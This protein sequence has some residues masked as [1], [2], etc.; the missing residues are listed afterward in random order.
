MTRQKKEAL[1]A[2]TP[3]ASISQRFAVPANQVDTI[4]VYPLGV[5]TIGFAPL[6]GLPDGAGGDRGSIKG[7]S[8]D[9]RR[10]FREWLVTHESRSSC[11]GLT[12][13]IPGDIVTPEVWH[14][15]LHALSV[16]CARSKVGLVWRLELQQR[17]QAHLHCI[18]T[19]IWKAGRVCVRNARAHAPSGDADIPESASTLLWWKIT[20]GK[21]LDRYA[22]KCDGR[23]FDGE[24]VRDVKDCPR[25]LLLGADR[26]M[27]DLS[28]DTG[29]PVW[30]RYLCDH[31]TKSKQAQ[32]CGWDGVRHWGKMHSSAFRQ[33]SPEVWTVE[34]PLYLIAYRWIRNSTRR[35]IKDERAPFG[36]R[37][38]V[39][40]RWNCAGSSVWFGVSGDTVQRVLK[41]ASEKAAGAG[42]AQAPE[43]TLK[44][45]EW[46]SRHTHA[47][48]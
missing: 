37:K 32:V 11:F 29:S 43:K 39:S 16:R 12:L 2:D 41:L 26:H 38:G 7:W 33:V 13:T 34:R 40:P 47:E 20:W 15:I 22:P 44:R 23:I 31:A 3:K 8:A 45:L 17:G 9:S 35:R 24:S 6:R 10:R 1:G 18:T 48:V 27:V 4:E 46:V 30:V 5:K 42:A 36:S 25:S 14:K 28:P 21:I 19:S